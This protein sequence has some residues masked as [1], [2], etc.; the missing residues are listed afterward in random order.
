MH[1]DREAVE[2][3]CYN[4]ESL[5]TDEKPGDVTYS[6]DTGHHYKYL[7]MK[8]LRT[9]IILSACL[10]AA[11][12]VPVSAELTPFDYCDVKASAP[13]SVKE[14]RPLADGVSYAAI[15]TDGR[16]IEVF[17]Y[18][19]GKQTGTLF[20]IDAVKG[21][22]K[23][24]EFDG[25]TL[26]KNEKKI[27]LWNNVEKIYRHSFTADY[28][29]YDVMRGTLA[30]VSE[31]GAQRGAVL[32]HDGRMVAYT[33]E[34]NIYVAN[35]DYGTDVAVTT[36]GKINELIY[37]VPDWGYEEEFGI[38]N[39]IRWSDDDNLL[40]FVRFDES[41]VPTYSFDNYRSY[42]DSDPDSD[43][44]PAQ[45]SYKYPLAGCNNSIVSV[46]S[47]DLD[48]RAIKKMD[49]PI[50][51]TDYVPSME[52][53][54][55]D[56][57]MVMILNRDQNCLRLFNTNPR[58]T[59]GRQIMEER[60][61]AWLSPSAYQ[62]VDYGQTTFVIGSERSGNCHLYEYDYSGTLKRQITK[63]DFN[64]TAYYGHNAA[65]THYV[66]TTSLGAINRTVAAVGKGGVKL[67]HGEAGWES[68]EF[69][70][71]HE[72]YLRRYSNATTPTQ[73]TIWT[74]KGKKLAEVEMNTEYAAKYAEAP[75]MEFLKVKN[76]AGQEMDA[77][78]IKPTDFDPSRKYPLLTYQYNGP[79]S[80]Q[81]ANRWRM[82]GI[83]YIASQGYVVACVDG[84]GTGYRTREW[85]NAVYKRLGTLET[86]DQLAGAR[87]FGSLPYV[88]E[89]R[90]ACFGWSFGGY[91]TLMEMTDPS[92]PF[93]CGVSMAP[94]TDWRFY[95]SIYT[96]RY[97]QTPQQ[98]EAGYKS[99]SAL[100]R[101]EDLKGKLL[102][103]SG[104]SDD[105]VHFYNTLKF[106]SKLN[107]EGK[108]FDMMAFTGFEHSLPMCNAREM[109]FR[110]VVQF[111]D[112]NLK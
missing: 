59:V 38:E 61:Q 105:N 96:E 74:S 110:K 11:V 78:I 72:Y 95:D 24:S 50:G 82:E 4:R 46:H 51:E 108:L 64:V 17:S 42:C 3:S 104:T 45:Y 5:L 7:T 25:Y 111:L 77:F 20:D 98:N 87:Y 22:L 109:L 80:Q 21:D 58:S 19:T 92:S 1:G 76:D 60:S 55:S 44:Y 34:N 73:Y 33:F 79:D 30:R 88:D 69:S 12:T 71:N 47:Y 14:M 49:L 39:T 26:S 86:A 56:R 53:A 93:K 67:L 84:R 107:Y 89:T 75:K 112:S 102:I 36:D 94:V 8:H 15:S 106:T 90:M 57:L 52:F 91:M 41:Q 6:R 16:R 62:M 32:S 31:R 100:A 35:L 18:K 2:T 99:S 28:F 54:G 10:A 37:G 23:I 68:A 66:Q 63:G 103:M 40:A 81:V 13:A 97:M 65:G 9:N 29:V 43:L 27:L 48:T 85:A 101:T 70:G 83:Y